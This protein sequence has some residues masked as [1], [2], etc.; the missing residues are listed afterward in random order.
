MTDEKSEKKEILLRQ[1]NPL[2]ESRYD[3]SRLEKNAYYCVVRQ[4]RRDYVE[5]GRKDFNNMIVEISESVLSEISDQDHTADAR[6]ALINLRHRDINIIREDGSWFN[7]GFINWSEYDA[8][9]HVYKLEVSSKLM[10]YL[11]ELSNCYTEYSLTVAISLKSKWSQ[12]MYELCSQHKKERTMSFWKTIEQ[13]RTMFMLDKEYSRITDFQKYTITKAEKELK[14]AFE[15]GQCDLW[16]ETLKEGR[17]KSTKFTFKIHTKE[18]NKQTETDGLA[19]AN[20]INA[21][22]KVMQATFPKDKKYVERFSS[23]LNFNLDKAEEVFELL[24][25][26]HKKYKKPAIA[27]VVRAV[28]EQE[29]GIK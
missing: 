19:L 4:V 13:L 24:T 21:M 14:S 10:P 2:T 20:K 28:L 8:Q 1:A 27:P 26:L 9:K 18:D 29:E 16:F 15:K 17:G 22:I 23:W 11:V 7:C 5:T 3:F 12:R 6:E 25:K